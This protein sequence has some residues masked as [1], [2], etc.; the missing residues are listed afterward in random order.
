[1]EYNK[2]IA[3]FMGCTKCGTGIYDIPKHTELRMIINNHIKQ[4]SKRVSTFTVDQLKYHSSWDWLM[5]VI[6]KI[7]G[8]DNFY[9]MDK[10]QCLTCDSEKMC[11]AFF[12]DNIKDAY[13]IVVEFIKWFNKEEKPNGK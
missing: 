1:M 10:W 7:Q 8:M 11:L 2:L 4:V 13:E 9:S 3:E 12:N 6:S 5:S